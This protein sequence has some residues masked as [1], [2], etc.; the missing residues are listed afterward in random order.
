MANNS[1]SFTF[2]YISKEDNLSVK[3]LIQEVMTEFGAVGEGYSIEDAEV[4]EMYEAYDNSK[5]KFWV[6]KK[7]GKIV[8]CGGIAPLLG[9]NSETCE[10]RKMYFYKEA[11]G[12]GMGKKMVELC[13]EKAKELG[14]KN[15]YLE[16]I[17][18]MEQANSLYK[19]MGFKSTCRMG[20]TGHSA[21]GA[22]Y[23]RSL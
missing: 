11:R 4:N 13:L 20:A 10:L 8:G 22:F 18:R 21:C 12:F 19:K 1:P 15:M 9:G 23:V 17:E 6:L 5:S 2:E 16:T 3:K 7:Q 14:Y